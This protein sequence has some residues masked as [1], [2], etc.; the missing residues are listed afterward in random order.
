VKIDR[1]YIQLIDQDES[2][3]QL[4]RTIVELAHKL[5]MHATAEGVEN[6][7]QLQQLRSMGCDFGQGFLFAAS[8]APEAIIGML[9]K[10]E[11]G[12]SLLQPVS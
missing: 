12:E 3:A 4:V 10:R 8:Q 11:R 7:G 5:G 9:E 6:E 1:A 2:G